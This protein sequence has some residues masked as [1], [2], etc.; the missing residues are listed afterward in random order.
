MSSKGRFVW[1]ELLTKDA[2]AAK[3]FY[4]PVVGWKAEAWEESSQPYSIWQI[5]EEQVGG[6]MQLSPEHLEGG[7]RPQWW[8]HVTVEDV[9]QAAS[10]AEELGGTIQTPP[11]DIPQI[12]RFAVVADPLGAILSLFKPNREAPPPE[13]M[14]VGH[15]AWN[16]LDTSDYES[17]WNFYSGLFGWKRAGSMDLGEA[18]KYVTFRHPDDAEEQSMG[19]MFNAAKISE[20]PVTWLYYIHVAAIEPALERVTKHGGKV[21]NGPNDVPGGRAA[22]CLDNQGVLFALFSEE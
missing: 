17:T 2:E 14:K 13:M 11:T 3:A 9:D 18:G 16:E 20:M 4:E 1:Y 7:T 8:A 10:R 22:Q 21:L 15:I 19:G 6:L 12:G 5:G